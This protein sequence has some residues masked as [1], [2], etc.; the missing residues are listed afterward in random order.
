MHLLI[1]THKRPKKLR[2]LLNSI[3]NAES[4][5]VIK[6][7]YIIENGSSSAERIANSFSDRLPIQYLH[8]AEGNKSK[9]LNAALEN[10]P[11]E[12]LLLFFDDDILV[13]KNLF[14]SYAEVCPRFG[15]GHYFGGGHR[16]NY[17]ITPD[18]RLVPYF[19]RSNRF[20]DLA[21]EAELKLF[22]AF[23]EFLGFNWACYHR[24]LINIGG[25]S[26]DFGP[27][28]ASG[29]RGQETDAQYR[30]YENGVKAV[31]IGDAKVDH[32]V[33]A[34]YISEDWLVERIFLSS[35]HLGKEKSSFMKSLGLLV[36]LQFSWLQIL[37]GNNSIGP[38]YRIAKAAGYFKGLIS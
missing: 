35:M 24:D 4:L 19:P 14:R 28:S 27:G 13:D 12:A 16:P 22:P 9:A 25:F 37:L 32:F 6:R 29:A 33:P 17:E 5:E 10:I 2:A 18:P 1:P 30:L 21:G 34:K 31:A 26:P 15:P 38:R 3:L 7:I 20:S 11:A 8:R 23:Q 36:K